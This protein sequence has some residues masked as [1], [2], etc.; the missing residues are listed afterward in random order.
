[1]FEIQPGGEGLL[2]GPLGTGAGY[3]RGN[4]GDA[5]GLVDA[6]G[7]LADSSSTSHGLTPPDAG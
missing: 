4:G 7:D 1:M 6:S 3:R 2:W 5:Q